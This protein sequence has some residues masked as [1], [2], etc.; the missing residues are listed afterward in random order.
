MRVFAN[1]IQ[2]AGL[3]FTAAATVAITPFV[4]APQASAVPYAYP[5]DRSYIIDKGDHWGKK[6]CMMASRNR[7]YCYEN[8]YPKPVPANWMELVP[9]IAPN[10]VIPGG[11]DRIIVN[12]D[13]HDLCPKGC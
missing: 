11:L 4:P 9:Y 5:T 8:D 6:T 12:G 2:S 7:L 3:A 1:K 10:P 13:S